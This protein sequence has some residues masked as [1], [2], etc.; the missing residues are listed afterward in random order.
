MVKAD[1]CKIYQITTWRVGLVFVVAF[2]V[3]RTANNKKKCVKILNMQI[4]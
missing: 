2:Q 1:Y 3:S 4:K